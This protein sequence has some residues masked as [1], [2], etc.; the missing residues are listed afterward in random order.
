MNNHPDTQDHASVPPEDRQLTLLDGAADKF[1]TIVPEIQTQKRVAS[2][3]TRPL[4]ERLEAFEDVMESEVGDTTLSRARNVEREVGL[5]QIYLKFEGGNPSG[6]HKDRIAFTQVMDALRRGF[7]GV[8][9]ATCGNYGVAMSFAASVAG[10]RCVI[11]IPEAYHSKR[12]KEM[13][14]FGAEII[15]AGSDYERAVVNSREHAAAHEIYD[16][17]PGS[18]NTVLQLRAYGEIAYEIYD[19]LR[20]AP[21]AVAI[22]VSNGTTLAG[23]YRGFVSLYRRGKT[24]RIPRFVAGSSFNKN[25]IVLAY[26]KNLPTCQDLKPEQI[27]ETSVNEPLINWHSI[28]GDLALDALRETGGFAA[29]A[30]D[31]AMLGF[32][33]LI[34]EQEGLNVLPASTAGLIA[35]MDRH[36]Q[37][38]L[39]GDRYV[40][41]LTGR[42]G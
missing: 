18:A 24:S 6:T 38:P 39:P 11:Y 30:S 8:T 17:N 3:P 41:V 29:N 14:R 4:E 33:R 36:R 12:V 20:D 21:A 19:E 31:K 34:R 40:V 13:E 26:R 35:L 7:E 25:P 5:R 9:M 15:K 10:L 1:Q 2:D 37:T 23:V 42:R 16:A 27:R 32:S 28:D 22:P